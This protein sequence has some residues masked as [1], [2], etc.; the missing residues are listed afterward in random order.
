[1]IEKML[2]AGVWQ[3]I[4]PMLSDLGSTLHIT[5]RKS[6]CFNSTKIV[7]LHLATDEC[8]PYIIDVTIAWAVFTPAAV[9][10]GEEVVV[11]EYVGT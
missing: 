4:A 7:H 5:L 3:S 2:D 11:E 1:M 8:T 10:V 6:P 9:S